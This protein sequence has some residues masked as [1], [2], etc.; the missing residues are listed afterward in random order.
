[1]FKRRAGVVPSGAR[2]ASARWREPGPPGLERYPP[3][4]PPASAGGFMGSIRHAARMRVACVLRHEAGTRVACVIRHEARS[5][6]DG[7]PGVRFIAR[8]LRARRRGLHTWC[9]G[10]AA[11]RS[12]PPSAGG[13]M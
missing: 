10:T 3:L 11:T 4:D 13:F 12:P 6:S 8:F 2:R 9:G 1:M 5:G 7:T